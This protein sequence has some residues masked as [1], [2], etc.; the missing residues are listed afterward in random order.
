MSTQR[1]TKATAKKTQNSNSN[2][3]KSK[4][5]NTSSTTSSSSSSSD[6]LR[7]CNFVKGRHI[8]CEKH[9][10]IQEVYTK[11]QDNWLNQGDRVPPSEFANLANEYSECPSSKRGGDL[12]WFPRGKM[13]G[14][15]QN[16]AFSAPI[17]S[18]S[19]IFRTA[20]GYHIFLCEGRKA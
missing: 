12:G 13:V 1:R 8:L 7:T 5:S 20:H 6:E 17:G 14:E 10:K 11:L 2:S 15:F 9:N 16:I 3:K 19:Q 4:S 18:V